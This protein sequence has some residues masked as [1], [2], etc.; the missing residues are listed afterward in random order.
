V[1]LEHG[2]GGE[3]GR[4]RRLP[5]NLIPDARRAVEGTLSPKTYSIRNKPHNFACSR[6]VLPASN[7]IRAIGERETC[8]SVC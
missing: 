2:S 5:A 1:A 7:K 3:A 6:A 8:S 4:G